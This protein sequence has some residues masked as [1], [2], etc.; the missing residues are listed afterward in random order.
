MTEHGLSGGDRL[1]SE[2]RESV[3]IVQDVRDTVVDFG[4][5]GEKTH[6]EIM[7]GLRTGR[8]KRVTGDEQ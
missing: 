7:S 8:L 5:A 2:R 1:S 4:D 6:R 3:L